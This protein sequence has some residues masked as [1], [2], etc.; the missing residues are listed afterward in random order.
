M[1]QAV[2][3]LF[4]HHALVTASGRTD[5]GVHALC[6]V[7]AFTT[8]KHRSPSEVCLGLNAALPD[9][10]A[11]THAELAPLEFEPRHWVSHKE[12]RYCFLNRL[13]RSP[14]F[15]DR[16]WQVRRPLDLAAM[17]EAA[18]HLIGTHDF[19]SFQAAGCQAAHPV[20]TIEGIRVERE[21]EFVFLTVSGH[22]FLRH[23]VRIIAGS[24]VDVG[25]SRQPP[26]WMHQ[27]LLARDRTLAG[28]TAPAKGLTLTRVDMGTAPHPR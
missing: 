22:G 16:S 9:D 21:G 6:Q 27:V 19:S 17:T 23:M 15:D 14:L 4:G 3:H 7:V 10:V 20:R 8:T 12:Y 2:A 18:Q 5:A 28:R 26:E 11:V 25:L 1:E 24:L 13:T